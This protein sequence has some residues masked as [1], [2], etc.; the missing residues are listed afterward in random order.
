[1]RAVGDGEA[2]IRLDMAAS[3]AQEAQIA[4]SVED[5]R[6]VLKAVDQGGYS[7]GPYEGPSRL[8]ALCS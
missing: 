7:R 8:P 4:R 5:I 3:D 1:M 6:M 2:V